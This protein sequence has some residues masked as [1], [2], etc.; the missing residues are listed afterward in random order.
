MQP[1]PPHKRPQ[2]L[3]PHICLP[4][5]TSTSVVMSKAVSLALE[6]VFLL[7]QVCQDTTTAAVVPQAIVARRITSRMSLS[8]VV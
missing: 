3:V 2:R 8:I 4:Y 6:L 5:Q 1:H 7:V